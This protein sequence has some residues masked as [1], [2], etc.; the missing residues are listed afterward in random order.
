MY[1]Y[2]RDG[3]PTRSVLEQTV[4]ALDNGKYCLAFPSGCAA[5]STLLHTLKPGDHIV[6]GNAAYGGTRTL[7]LH[8]TKSQNM[9]VDFVDSTCVK[10]VEK[11]L[12]PNTK[13]NMKN[14]YYH[15]N[16]F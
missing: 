16:I 13:V 6:C 12:K 10:S 7:L 4:A 1:C 8:Y 14:H 5:L 2:D 15:F 11:A 9:E 3:N